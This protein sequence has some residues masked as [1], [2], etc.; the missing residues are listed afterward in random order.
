MNILGCF[1]E[2][3][4]YNAE[5]IVA[6]WIRHEISVLLPFKDVYRVTPTRTSHQKLESDVHLGLEKHTVVTVVM[7]FIVV[8]SFGISRSWRCHR[9]WQTDGFSL[10]H[11]QKCIFSLF[12]KFLL[13]LSSTTSSSS[14][15]SSFLTSM[16]NSES[17]YKHLVLQLK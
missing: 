10:S 12:T 8:T 15:S 11:E 16:I 6:Y 13:L 3:M 17:E 1:T 14:W 2:M 9:E 7:V 5:E 4:T